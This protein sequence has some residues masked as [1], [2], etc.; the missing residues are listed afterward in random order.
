MS[1]RRK[2]QGERRKEIVSYNFIA[3]FDI[4]HIYIFI[5]ICI[6]SGPIK[7]GMKMNDIMDMLDEEFDN[8]ASEVH[9]SD[10]NAIDVFI[11]PPMSN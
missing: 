11:S 4:F 9:H 6:Y 2:E 7:P 8:P 1:Q 3:N 10:R 5:Y